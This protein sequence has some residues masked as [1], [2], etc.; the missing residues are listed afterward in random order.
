[1]TY[2]AK[3]QEWYCHICY[4]NI[5]FTCVH[6]L[7]RYKFD[8]VRFVYTYVNTIYTMIL[9]WYYMQQSY[10]VCQQHAIYTKIWTFLNA[11][12]SFL[13]TSTLLTFIDGV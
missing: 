4:Q 11:C 3:Y 8:I 10:T 6:S 2:N 1:M 7:G 9:I 5:I 13:F 12:L